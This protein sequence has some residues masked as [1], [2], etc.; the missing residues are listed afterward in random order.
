MMEG[1]GLGAPRESRWRAGRGEAQS[2]LSAGHAQEHL[3]GN[4]PL[5]QTPGKVT[6]LR[7]IHLRSFNFF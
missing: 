1:E 6:P 3:P 5:L 7:E 2:G 4:S